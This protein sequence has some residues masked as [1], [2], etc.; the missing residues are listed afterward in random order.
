VY[1]LPFALLPL[2]LVIVAAVLVAA[3][4]GGDPPARAARA[5][6]AHVGPGPVAR[7]L[8]HGAYRVA[9]QLSPNRPTASNRLTVRVT[10]AGRA[11]T[12]AKVTA[13][14]DMV[15][16]DMGNWTYE[17]PEHAAGRYGRKTSSPAMTGD[18]NL[19]VEVAPRAGAPFTVRV[20]DRA[21]V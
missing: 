2:V 18:W 3:L 14:F 9:L 20:V 11:V 10:R 17:L 12:A 8:S 13:R 1:R 19:S 4:T 15:E 6:T 7:S 16:M 21:G 5:T